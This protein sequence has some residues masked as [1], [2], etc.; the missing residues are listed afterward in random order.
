MTKSDLIDYLLTL[1]YNKVQ[2]VIQLEQ[3]PIVQSSDQMYTLMPVALDDDLQEEGNTSVYELRIK[4]LTLDDE[5]RDLKFTLFKTLKINI[6][7]LGGVKFYNQPTFKSDVP[8]HQ[9][10]GQMNFYLFD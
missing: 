6:E 9:S 7:G 4:Y 8:N 5:M 2:E 3:I 1:S 10:I